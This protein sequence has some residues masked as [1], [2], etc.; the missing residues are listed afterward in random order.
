[1][2][3]SVRWDNDLRT[4][5]RFT[6]WNEWEIT[7]YLEAFDEALSMIN[8]VVD[9]VDII[10][11]LR[12]G[13][14]IPEGD[15]VSLFRNIINML[16]TNTGIIVYINDDLVQQRLYTVQSQFY[17]ITNPRKPKRL[18]VVKKLKDALQLIEIVNN[19]RSKK[20]T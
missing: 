10:N 18:F 17:Q 6:F 5:L 8:A 11:D 19:S 12:S 15:T 14:F 20:Q 9:T 1:M 3:V 16:P 2:P 13:S 7:Q 4:I